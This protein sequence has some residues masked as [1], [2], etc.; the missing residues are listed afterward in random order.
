MASK[1]PRESNLRQFSISL[2]RLRNDLIY[3]QQASG[4]KSPTMYV[5]RGSTDTPPIAFSFPYPPQQIQ[6]SNMSP[7]ISEIS[8]PGKVPLIAF[9]RFRAKQISFKFLLAVPLDGLSQSIDNDIE[10]LQEMANTARPVYFTNMDRQ[11]SNPFN[12]GTG[13][14]RIF[15]SIIDLTFSSIRR[16][17]RNEIVAAE[18][19]ITL[20]ENNNPKVKATDLP[21]LTYTE[22]PPANNPSR[23]GDKEVEYTHNSYTQG[24]QREKATG[25]PG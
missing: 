6:Y 4:I 8:R 16:N 13:E 24:Q 9:N 22:N 17:E 15:W 14:L 18:A 19:N 21:Q 20:V 11:I 10:L 7:E 3:R 2:N 12:V 5:S 1:N 23:S 25:L